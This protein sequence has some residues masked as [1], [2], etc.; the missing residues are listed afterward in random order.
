MIQQPRSKLAV[1]ALHAIFCITGVA[2][3]PVL[4]NIAEP[5]L[6]IALIGLSLGLTI[7]AAKGVA[8]GHFWRCA[9][10]GVFIGAVIAIVVYVFRDDPH[11][12]GRG[13]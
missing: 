13:R 11:R 10:I 12:I 7:G 6:S 9:L 3:V 1:T 5:P 4:N 2:S 8:S